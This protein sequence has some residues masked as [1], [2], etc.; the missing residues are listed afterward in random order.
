MYDTGEL[1]NELYLPMHYNLVVVKIYYLG[2][3]IMDYCHDTSLLHL[4][5]VL[6]SGCRFQ[7]ILSRDI[8]S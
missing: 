3:M 4:R 8:I 7:F 6:I 5:N 1:V 2:F